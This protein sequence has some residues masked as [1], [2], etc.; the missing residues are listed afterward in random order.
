MIQTEIISDLE[1]IYDGLDQSSDSF[2]AAYGK[3]GRSAKSLFRESPINST[4]KPVYTWR[5]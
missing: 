5:L 4:E 3:D 2:M 1:S